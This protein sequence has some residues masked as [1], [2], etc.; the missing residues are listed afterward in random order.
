MNLDR[1]STLSV[2]APRGRR[3]FL[4][5]AGAAAG[6]G[7]LASAA[8][9]TGTVDAAVTASKF[10]PL[11]KPYRLAD[12]REAIG[13]RFEA[14]DARVT[15]Q[16]TRL[17]RNL[18][19][20][21]VRDRLDVPASASAVVL[22]VTGS[23]TAVEA[24][25]LT[26]Y[27]SGE[28]RPEASNLNID[29]PYTD[30]GNLVFVK[31]GASDSVDIFQY[32]GCNVIVDVL[33]YFEPVS[34]TVREGRYKALTPYRVLD[35][36]ERGFR[37]TGGTSVVVD[38]GKFEL[39]SAVTQKPP[40]SALVNITAVDNAAGTFYSALP[41]SA[42]GV[43]STSSFN[44]S[45]GFD[46]RAGAAI[47]AVEMVG[48]AAK[49]RVYTHQT[50]HIIVDVLGYFTGPSDSASSEGLF[51]P[52]SPLRV[53]D[54]RV[55]D[56]AA[57][58]WPAWVV[59]KKLP[60]S[61]PSQIGAAVINLTSTETRNGGFLSING[62]R[63]V[64]YAPPKTSNVNWPAAGKTVPN[65][66]VT[67]MATDGFE[68]YTSSGSHIVADLAGYFTGSP[69]SARYAKYVNPAPPAAPPEWSL[70]IPKLG[71]TSRVLA[72]VNNGDSVR[73]TD[74]GHSWHWT[75]TGYLGQAA[76]V[77]AFAHRTE[78]ATNQFGIDPNGRV[79][80]V[81]RNIHYLVNG[82]EWTVFTSD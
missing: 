66:T 56:P 8:V 18:I 76:H 9:A 64:S 27:P 82:D 11:R 5:G 41:Y 52:M 17:S 37:V 61:V 71:I 29:T 42:A 23:T 75:G 6:A 32:F 62:A 74:A 38:L 3:A 4:R 34:G 65:L 57:R 13:Y 54:T 55:P 81:F 39:G 59:E 26:V 21:K 10:V 70:Q 28:A 50:A 77:A 47:V 46:Q 69:A 24:R 45:F 36:R 48:G 33:G 80:G 44:T 35:T 20:V 72:G 49:M 31:V 78:R 15:N 40:S 58:L 68:V 1:E 60:S 16:Y 43:P 79:D 30:S 53:L 7:V 51:V 12:T 22:T 19:R 25:Y 2:D 14:G 63:Q 73:I 67:R